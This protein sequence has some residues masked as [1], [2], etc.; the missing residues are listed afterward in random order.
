MLPCNGM[1]FAPAIAKIH[2]LCFEQPWSEEQ[3]A[4]LL[5]LP[6]CRLWMNENGFLLCSEVSGEM[7]ILT[8]CVLPEKRRQH[9]AEDLLNQLF[10]YAKSKNI[11]RIFLEVAKDNPPAQKL[12]IK[13]G[14][15]LSGE[16][17]KY[18][19]RPNGSVD[20]LCFTKQIKGDIL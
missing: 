15:T 9:V 5:S 13:T 8:I 6:T 17:K 16:R 12:Y 14:F 18:Y 7:E 4:K 11:Q 20:A 19:A 3:F 2:E 10:T 1:A